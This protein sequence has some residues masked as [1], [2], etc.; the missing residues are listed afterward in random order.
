MIKKINAIKNFGIFK[1][2]NWTNAND[3]NE[4]NIIYGWNYSGK[5]TLSRIFSSLKNKELHE[6]H[7][8]GEFKVLI[9]ENDII[10]NS[11][12]DQS[13]IQV[14]VF[15]TEYI[16][17]NL[18]W[19]T[20][21]DANGIEFDVGENVKVRDE[22]KSNTNKIYEIDERIKN[23]QPIVDAFF[24]F[25]NTKFSYE[26]KRIRKDILN[27]QIEF[28]KRHFKQTINQIKENG[29]CYKLPD[30][31]V[32]KLKDTSIAINN[33]S[34]LDEIYLDTN[35]INQIYLSVKELLRREPNKNQ[36][37]DILEKNKEL[38]EWAKHGQKIHEAEELTECAYCGNEITSARLDELNNYFSNES[39]LLRE[40]IE[41]CRKDINE[42]IKQI[43]NLN[44]PKSKNDF[45][46]E[47]Q[48][49]FE[50]QLIQF[51][52]I[53]QNYINLLKLFIED[54]DRKEKEKL[55]K[56][57][58]TTEYD[59]TNKEQLEEWIT[60]TN[61][62]IKEHNNFVSNFSSEQH[63][64]QERLKK[65]FVQEFLLNEDFFNK[66]KEKKRASRYI[67]KY[68][69]LKNK[70]IER[71][72]VL[73]RKLKSVVAGKDILNKYIALFLNDNKINIEVTAND[74]FQLKRNES[75]AINLSEGEKTAISFAYFL[76]S[77]ESLH[78]EDRLKETII[79]IDDPI[80]SLDSNH[81]AQV[82]SIING[83]FFRQGENPEDPNEYVNCFKQLFIS[84]HNFDFYSF[85]KD[86]KR[87]GKNKSNHFFIKKI[88]DNNSTIQDMPKHLQRNR[89]EYVYLFSIIYKYYNND[90][91]AN[92]ENLILLPNAIRRF[93]EIYTLI[94]LPGA[95]GGVDERLKQ[96]GIEQNQ[97]KILHHLSHFT[98]V[99]NLTKHD[100]LLMILPDTVDELINMLRN[101]RVHFDS[102]IS[103]IT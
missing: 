44:I 28:N 66:E 34:L 26:A 87:I 38:Y 41:K 94:K 36:I 16:K 75:V 72:A 65:H 40:S 59:F 98:S 49:Q 53:K 52:N 61:N 69:C 11:N 25:E 31:K 35:K 42:E 101:D 8:D 9:N 13:H 2:F 78:K 29:K 73:E 68:N 81:I 91:D 17:E 85:L 89:S 45:A 99:D 77:L 79:F 55:F 93:L 10:S 64:A 18:K 57:I 71:N 46:E 86:S 76:V 90:F 82:Y 21:E 14:Q 97:L 62:I 43:S 54:L 100:E 19:D 23:F 83:F 5:T 103:I 47:F 6:N 1:D 7:T 60:N 24:E 51:E 22:M 27:N 48:N 96:L 30:E 92:D 80:S 63:Y 37:I 39:G 32:N 4:K 56:P 70:L 88:D 95:E 15:N 102:L 12:I 3:F 67:Q 20:N 74:K 84:T 58:E 50:Q 33:K